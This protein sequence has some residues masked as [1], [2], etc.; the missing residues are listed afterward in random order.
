MRR[1]PALFLLLL[2]VLAYADYVDD[3]CPELFTDKKKGGTCPFAA[4]EPDKCFFFYDANALKAATRDVCLVAMGL[5]SQVEAMQGGT[6]LR[7]PR[8]R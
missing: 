1:L 8:V 5:K 2:P 4:T 6:A 3:A 7:Q